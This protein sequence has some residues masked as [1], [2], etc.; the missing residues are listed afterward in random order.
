MILGT[1]L[2]LI[3]LGV[4]IGATV[5]LNDSPGVEK[6]TVVIMMIALALVVWGGVLLYSSAFGL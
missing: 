3:G 1:I 5:T 2:L 4:F 6:K